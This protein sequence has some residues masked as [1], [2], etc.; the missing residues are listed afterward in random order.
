[1]VNV[2][3]GSDDNSSTTG[4]SVTSK[5]TSTITQD[6]K[7]KISDNLNNISF[8]GFLPVVL[9]LTT[10]GASPECQITYALTRLLK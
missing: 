4:S 3:A 8:G 7:S 1:M 9:A 10:L 2:T 5:P 6:T